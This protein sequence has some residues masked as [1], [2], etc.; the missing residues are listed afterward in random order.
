MALTY[1][2]RYLSILSPLVGIVLFFILK[3]NQV[4]TVNILM[5]LLALG[6]LSD[7]LSLFLTKIHLTTIIV[8][9]T[10]VFLQLLIVGLLYIRILEGRIT[11]I[12]TFILA[13]TTGLFLLNT[14]LFQSLDSIQNINWMISALVIMIITFIHLVAMSKTPVYLIGQFPPFW[15]TTGLFFYCSLSFLILSF[16]RYLAKNYPLDEF[17]FVWM[18]HNIM[19]IFKNLCFAAA[20]WWSAKRDVEIDKI[21]TV[22]DKVK[23][24]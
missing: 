16:S 17:Q 18:F 9:N 7:I 1:I 13:S 6:L 10:F 8:G 19:N 14:L 22:Y 3:K 21:I 4:R 15:I 23:A 12:V 24:S 5:C 2:I 20:I 11:K